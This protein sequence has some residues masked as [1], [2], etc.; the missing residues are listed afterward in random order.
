M[1]D[2]LFD[3]VPLDE[4]FTVLR[5]ASQV[6]A[7]GAICGALEGSFLAG[8]V[9]LLLTAPE[10]VELA[11]GAALADTGLAFATGLLGGFLAFSLPRRV[12]RWRRDR[13]G[14]SLAVSLF[15]GFFFLPMGI[16]LVRRDDVPHAVGMFTLIVSLGALAWFNAG[17]WYRRQAIGM[18]PRIG[19]KIPGFSMATLICASAALSGP[20]I[21]RIAPAP[22]ESPN[23]FVISIDTLRRDHVGT[24]GARLPTPTFDRLAAEGAAFDGAI[25]PL[26]ETAPSHASMFTGLHPAEHDVV[27]NGRRLNGGHVTAAEQL[28]L[29]GW[30]TGAF[31]SAFALDSS[32]G[33]DQGFHVYDDDFL[34]AFRGLSEFRAGQ[35]G[36]KLLMRF[37]N[38]AE[39]PALLERNAPGT[40][41]RALAWIDGVPIAQPV[42][43]WV[44][45]FEPHSPYDPHAGLSGE[46]PLSLDHRPILA[47][48]PGH[49]YSTAEISSLRV[50]YEA[51]VT[52]VDGQIG[53]F[54]AGLRQRGR[55][56]NAM[57]LIVSDHGESLGEHGIMFNHHGL[58][59]EVLRVPLILWESKGQE[60]A[61]GSRSSAQVSVQDVANTVLESAGVPLL[62]NTTSL[63]LTY[64]LTGKQVRAEPV[65]LMGRSDAAWLYGVRSP[66]G[67]KY[68]VAGERE[69]V[70][71]LIDDPKE[72]TD[73]SA[74]QPNAVTVGRANVA[75][76]QRHIDRSAGVAEGAA[77]ML[78]ALGYL[79][80]EGAAAPGAGPDTRAVEPPVAP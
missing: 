51:E 28:S 13:L 20:A 3:V 8:R 61:P 49:G 72:S 68:I 63:P 18:A 35:L 54:L 46:I 58:Y 32:T 21:P 65:L 41:R 7:V 24:F 34:P 10:R 23:V 79:E 22:Q 56:D 33:L 14:F 40:I 47:D 80:P 67:A 59:E 42:F 26:P 78:E 11:L 76:L 27:Q 57:V 66:R 64:H 71:D 30:R 53:E 75:M 6:A 50:Q 77:D 5:V 48:E 69:E 43:T 31:V 55:L 4:R 15:A 12:E 39:W 60:W 73:I 2:E 37:G 74:S 62:Q 38:P 52:Y 25:T 16:E 70:F 44:H 29:L 19:W 36:L 45:L 9:K 1:N 17:Y